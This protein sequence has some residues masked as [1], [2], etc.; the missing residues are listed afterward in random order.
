MK[1]LTTLRRTR[2]EE[3]KKRWLVHLDQREMLGV[4]E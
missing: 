4:K 1:V 2:G 3:E